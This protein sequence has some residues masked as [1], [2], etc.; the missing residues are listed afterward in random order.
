MSEE[1]KLRRDAESE[2]LSSREDAKAYQTVLS[3]L[4][5][6]P[7]QMLPTYFADNVIGIIEAGNRVRFTRMEMVCFGVVVF[8]LTVILFY[9]VLVTGFAMNWGFLRGIGRFAPVFAFGLAVLIFFHVLDKRLVRNPTSQ[10]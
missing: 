9:A 7:D 3:A 1:E 2:H 10:S 6:E 8:L 4:K 5:R